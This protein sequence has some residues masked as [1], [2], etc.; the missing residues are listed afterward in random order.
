ML[1]KILDRL[2]FFRREP[3]LVTKIMK[4]LAR[5]GGLEHDIVQAH[6]ALDGFLPP[7]RSGANPGDTRHIAFAIASMAAAALAYDQ[8]VA[9]S[10]EHTSELQS[11]LNLVC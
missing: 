4:N 2:G 7:F 1:G 3:L 9:R 5:I 11:H 10:E 8:R 6:H